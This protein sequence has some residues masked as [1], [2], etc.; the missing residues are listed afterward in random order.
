MKP[1][2]SSSILFTSVCFLS[3]LGAIGCTAERSPTTIR[4]V[5]AE[6]VP[7]ATDSEKEA[8]T[9]KAMNSAKN[10]DEAKEALY[11]SSEG[12]KS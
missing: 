11:T 1:N 10:Y 6:G 7:K 8:N 3:A 4:E 9:I 5:T 2:I 12:D